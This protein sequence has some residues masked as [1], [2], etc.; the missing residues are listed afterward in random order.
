M[1]CTREEQRGLWGVI[2]GVSLVSH[3]HGHI[4]QTTA[5]GALPVWGPFK[6]SAG[7][8]SPVA[9]SVL[10]GKGAD[11]L[12]AA[13]SRLRLGAL[14]VQVTRRLP[15]GRW[16]CS[17]WTGHQVCLRV[18]LP[19]QSVYIQATFLCFILS[20]VVFKLRCLKTFRSHC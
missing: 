2:E 20:L 11:V 16:P 15:D 12:T 4:R 9:T 1:Q 3:R 13:S 7:L 6:A 8:R 10:K 5:W 17:S 19:I 18:R 14:W